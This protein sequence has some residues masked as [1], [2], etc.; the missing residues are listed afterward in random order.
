MST[1]APIQLR[2]KIRALFGRNMTRVHVSDHLGRIGPIIGAVT[3]STPG[4]ISS[5]PGFSIPRPSPQPS[6]RRRTNPRM[7]S[8]QIGLEVIPTVRL[9][10]TGAPTHA[11]GFGPVGP[12]A[13]LLPL[14]SS[15]SG[16]PARSA[17]VPSTPAPPHR[18]RPST[19]RRRRGC[20]GAVP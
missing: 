11:P 3:W 19:A 14:C 2:H 6:R 20:A 4:R 5:P 17:P 16:L 7:I 8:D 13:P 9:G 15:E 10:D 1:T 18:S 12:L